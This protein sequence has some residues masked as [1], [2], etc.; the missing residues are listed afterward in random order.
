MRLPKV[1]NYSIHE[2]EV[3][4]LKRKMRFRPFL[5]KEY[6]ALII[7]ETSSDKIEKINTLKSIIQNCCLEENAPDVDSLAVFD[8]EYLLIKL[9]DIS[10]GGE[11]AL[12]GRC[13]NDKAHEGLD[14]KSRHSDVYLN[15]KN[16][17]LV[18]IDKYKTEIAIDKDTF[19]KMI[20][21]T[22]ELVETLETIKE[23]SEDV[24]TELIAKQIDCI[25]QG[26]EV[27]KVANNP[28][29]SLKDMKEWLENL[30]AEQFNR[31]NDYFHSIPY[32]QVKLEWTCPTCGHLNQV[33]L[34]GLD[35]F[36]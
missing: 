11:V 29:F 21:P 34:R 8:F 18:G 1:T 24:L 22:L 27:Y 12:D 33:Y 3:P 35:Y 31:L 17:E 9:R 13:Q 26:D 25:V 16:V 5:F 6:K 14:E 23:N 32:C 7:A 20:P 10:V 4:S 28:D 19:V 30:N 15:L 36:F 2:I